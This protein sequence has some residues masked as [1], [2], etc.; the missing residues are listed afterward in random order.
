VWRSIV[1]SDGVTIENVSN[2]ALHLLFW[3]G[4]GTR[5]SRFFRQPKAM[6]AN[7]ALYLALTPDAEGFER[8]RDEALELVL[9]FMK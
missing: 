3:S 4:C 1:I 7:V 5:I 9:S 8:D 2:A 6:L